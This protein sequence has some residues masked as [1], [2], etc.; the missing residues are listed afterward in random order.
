LSPLVAALP[1]IAEAEEVQRSMNYTSWRHSFLNLV[2]R[3]LAL[4][5]VDATGKEIEMTER[6]TLPNGRIRELTGHKV[7]GL[8]SKIDIGVLDPPGAGGASCRYVVF[9]PNDGF[10]QELNASV[11]QYLTFHSGP[12]EGGP[13]G[14]ITHEVLLAILEDRLVGM[15]AGPYACDDNAEALDHLR[16]VI[17]CLHRRTKKRLARGVEGKQ[18]A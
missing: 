7:N 10:N 17:E 11:V 16:C 13:Q 18:E 14:P 6:A 9:V 8:N 5:E 1:I 2:R 4:P 3:G 12:V 15:Q